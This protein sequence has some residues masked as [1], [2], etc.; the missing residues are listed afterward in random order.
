MALKS[1]I[2]HPPNHPILRENAHHQRVISMI[3]G[4]RLLTVL[5]VDDEAL[6]RWSIAELL[7]R[8]GHTV[9]EAASGNNALDAMAHARGPIDVVLLDYRLPDS[10]DLR[11]LEEVRRRLPQSAVVLM[12]AFGTPDMVQGA[13]DRGAYCVLNKPFDMHGVEGLITEAHRAAQY[14]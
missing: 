8:S 12:T 4:N 9:I 3:H 13:L 7:R 14:H 5:V 2:V 6:L 1:Y 10:N 11:L